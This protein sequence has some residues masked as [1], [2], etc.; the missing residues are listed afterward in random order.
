MDGVFG[1]REESRTLFDFDPTVRRRGG[2]RCCFYIHRRLYAD[3]NTAKR[4]RTV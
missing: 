2:V 3:E 1:G 4:G